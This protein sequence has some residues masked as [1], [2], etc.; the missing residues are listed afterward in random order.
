MNWLDF[1]KIWLVLALWISISWPV[2]AEQEGISSHIATI[3]NRQG[4]YDIFKKL[5][6][7]TKNQIEIEKRIPLNVNRIEVMKIEGN[8]ILISF[9]LP[10]DKSN[11]IPQNWYFVI[12]DINN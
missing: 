7:S 2:Q 12:D 9:D 10:N 5:E 3:L 11:K 4:I 8:K 1:P 6:I